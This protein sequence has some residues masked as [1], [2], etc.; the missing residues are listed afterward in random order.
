MTRQ[1]RW[2]AALVLLAGTC[3]A[4]ELKDARIRCPGGS[5][6]LLVDGI[7]AAGER[8]LPL[9]YLEDEDVCQLD[10]VTASSQ[11]RLSLLGSDDFDL[12]DSL[13]TTSAGLHSAK[14]RF[15]DLSR[16]QYLKV[17]IRDSSSAVAELPLEPFTRTELRLDT[18]GIQWNEGLEVAVEI[19]SNHPGNLQAF[20]VWR[21]G[22][23]FQYR[24]V[25]SQ[26]RVFLH[27]LPTS[28]GPCEVAIA[29]PLRKPDLVQG[30]PGPAE[31]AIR[32]HLLFRPARI[33]Y[34][35]LS[36]QTVLLDDRSGREGIE[37][38]LGSDQVLAPGR[39]YLLEESEAPGGPAI[40][41]LFVKDVLV[42]GHA[43][44]LL[45]T[46]NLH[47]RQSG[48][49]FVKEGGE[50]RAVTN[51]DILPQVRVTALK[52]MRNGRDWVSDAVI[53]PGETIHLRLEGVSL[54]QAKFGF[55]ELDLMPEAGDQAT[56][57]VFEC[58]VAVPLGISRASIPILDRGKPTGLALV[59]K[60]H[61]RAHPFDYLSIDYGTGPRPLSSVSGPELAPRTIRD[62]QIRL[63][64]KG[65][66][67]GAVL[68]GKQY[69]SVD[70]KVTGPS[71]NLL[72]VATIDDVVLCPDEHS[73]RYGYY[74]RS[75]CSGSVLDLNEHLS[76]NTY[77]LEPWSKISLTFSNEA[78]VYDQPRPPR[79]I[80]VY[81]QQRLRFDVDVSFPF[82]LLIRKYRDEGWGNFSG[83]SMAMMAKLGFYENGAI[84]R[85]EPYELAAGFIAL[86][87]FDLSQTS[88]S[89][90][91][92]VVALATLNPINPQRKLSFPI[93]F[94]GGYLLYSHE[95]FWLLGP[96]ISVQF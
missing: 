81:R 84:D 39:K 41:E 69:L 46:Y 58:K 94:G 65:L 2:L 40:G 80:D 45:R 59:V 24:L 89:R 71:G 62:L 50:V 72:D 9:R 90:D 31:V 52:I 7:D 56:E 67:T 76:I 91:L 47:R 1:G 8:R 32:E 95:W 92:G 11:G 68:Y 77:D 78:D 23:G 87:A 26:E 37:A 88:T 85:L 48:N 96:G 86:D 21:Q 55:G 12:V 93:Y 36:P 30:R 10:L 25:E 61:Q 49:L 19:L 66:D 15:Y 13:A 44:A 74:D 3:R 14:L 27:L 35:R 54:D 5:F 38:Q 33:A 34:L 18:A 73:R 60:E 82:G 53:H 17:R 43:V 29:L 6:S 20:P 28:T 51:L 63:D 75:D 64:P 42:G 16:T 57:T 79:R 4:L 83:V 70:V 22:K